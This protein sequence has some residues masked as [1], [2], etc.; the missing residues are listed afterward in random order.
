LLVCSAK[1]P[2]RFAIRG[3][4]E[5]QGL[6]KLK[7]PGLRPGSFNFQGG[8]EKSPCE[9][10]CIMCPQNMLDASSTPHKRLHND[11]DEAFLMSIKSTLPA[12]QIPE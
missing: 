1:T 12:G 8:E 10:N 3:G 2:R 5:N 7:E 11:F 4:G 9:R 6:L